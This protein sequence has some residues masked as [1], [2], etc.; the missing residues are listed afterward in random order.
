ML[1]D[2][3]PQEYTCGSGQRKDECEEVVC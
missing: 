1:R 3:D 2:H